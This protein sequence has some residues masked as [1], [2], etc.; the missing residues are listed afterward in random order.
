MRNITLTGKVLLVNSLVGSLFVYKMTVLPFLG[1]EFVETFN[2]ILRN[3]IWNDRKSKIA[4]N[5]LQADKNCGGLRLVDLHKKDM[6]LKLTWVK[7]IDKG[8]FFANVFYNQ[9]RLPANENIFKCQ[10]SVK[11]DKD[12]CVS[13][14]WGDVLS[15]WNS[16]NTKPVISATEVCG[17]TLWCNSQ[18]KINKQV[19]YNTRAWQAGMVTVADLFHDK[20]LLTYPQ[21]CQRFGNALTWFEYMQVVDAIPLNWKRKLQIEGVSWSFKGHNVNHIKGITAKFVYSQLIDNVKPLVRKVQKWERMLNCQLEIEEFCKFFV[22]TYT[23]TISSKL[24]DF[25]YRLL[26]HAII[27]NRHLFLWKLIES[28]LCTYC[29]KERETYTHLFF[30]CGMVKHLWMQV[31]IFLESLNLMGATFNVRNVLLNSVHTKANHVSNFVVLIVKQAIYRTRCL[32]QSIKTIKIDNEI[33]N[34]YCIEEA[35]AV[36]NSKWNRHVRKWK[37]LKHNLEYIEETDFV[38]DYINNLHHSQL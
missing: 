5:I 20:T 24:R 19:V 25:Q 34:I 1:S 15:A 13:P 38:T 21:L 30:E 17:Q 23:L 6:S 7:E 35:I 37:P 33:D 32:K 22:N 26:N 16:L 28:D 18:I 29:K 14:F 8:G 9:L 4:L 27:T 11:D 36:K 2:K 10:L 31:N 3:F 12:L